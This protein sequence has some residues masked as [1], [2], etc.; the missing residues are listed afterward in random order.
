MNICNSKYLLY[1]LVIECCVFT[2]IRTIIFWNNQIKKF[3][4]EFHNVFFLIQIDILQMDILS[5]QIFLRHITKMVESSLT[6][7]R[8]IIF[9]VF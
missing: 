3:P 5:L 9:M 2:L 4:R 7:S 8:M 6:L 1:S